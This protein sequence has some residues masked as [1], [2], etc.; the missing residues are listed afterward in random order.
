MIPIHYG[1]PEYRHLPLMIGIEALEAR[2]RDQLLASTVLPVRLAGGTEE[3]LAALGIV[4]GPV[5]ADDPIWCEA[6]MPAGW[7][8]RA[9]PDDHRTVFLV[10]KTDRD[11]V[12]LWYK[13]APYDRYA[14]MTLL[15]EE[16]S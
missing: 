15:S 16:G 11:R 7:S 5:I 2:G 1:R 8:R 12:R 4:L 9:D 14:V 3:D 13:A 6:T 10:D